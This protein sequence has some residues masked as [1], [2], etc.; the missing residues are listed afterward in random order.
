MTFLALFSFPPSGHLED[1]TPHFQIPVSLRGALASFHAGVRG[2]H[3]SDL[4]Q[5]GERRVGAQL[6]CH[7]LSW[8]VSLEISCG[9]AEFCAHPQNSR[10]HPELT[11]TDIF[12]CIKKSGN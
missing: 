10:E 1:Y 4:V 12:V 7:V 2:A 5:Q 3:I 6:P 11:K 8:G 9:K